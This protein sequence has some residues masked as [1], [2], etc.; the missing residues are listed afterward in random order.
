MRDPETIEHTD[1]TLGAIAEVKRCAKC[2]IY[3]C[4]DIRILSLVL[5]ESIL[6]I[7][8]IANSPIFLLPAV[9]VALGR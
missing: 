8:I 4:S 5:K 7:A 1:Q 2:G 9:M 3:P 6:G